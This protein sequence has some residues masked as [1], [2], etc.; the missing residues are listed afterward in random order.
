MQFLKQFEGIIGALIGVFVGWFLQ[1]LNSRGKVSLNFSN[2]NIYFYKYDMGDYIV[3]EKPENCI[4]GKISFDLLI[5]NQ[6]ADSKMIKDLTVIL[7]SGSSNTKKFLLDSDSGKVV[8]QQMRLD[9]VEFLNIPPK[10]IGKRRFE[11]LLNNIDLGEIAKHEIT[12]EFIGQKLY[13]LKGKISEQI[14]KYNLKKEKVADANKEEVVV[15]TVP[16]N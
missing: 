16:G 2:Q 8:N 6:S 5:C 13:G 7:K 3:Q 15:P 11:I 10:Y 4:N 1:Y 12:A 14:L 9:A